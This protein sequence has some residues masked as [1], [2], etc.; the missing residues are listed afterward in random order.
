MFQN[1][2]PLAQLVGGFGMG[3]GAFRLAQGRV[4][5]F[6]QAIDAVVVDHWHDFQKGN[7]DSQKR[8]NDLI[9]K[10]RKDEQ[11]KELGDLKNP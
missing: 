3:N 8:Q 6:E 10:K 2:Q 11:K 4:M 5:P 9:E 1:V 7:P